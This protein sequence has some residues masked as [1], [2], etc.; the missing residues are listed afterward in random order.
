MTLVSI[1]IWAKIPVHTVLTIVEHLAN[2]VN[3]N[4][5]YSYPII[6]EHLILHF[7]SSSF[8]FPTHQLYHFPYSIFISLLTLCPFPPKQCFHNEPCIIMN[9]CSLLSQVLYQHVCVCVSTHDHNV[10]LGSVR[11]LSDFCL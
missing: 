9:P 7:I 11:L 10:Y 3:G 5:R 2:Y 6:L 1:G 4:L 8:V